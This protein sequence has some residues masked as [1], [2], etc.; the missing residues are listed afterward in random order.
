MKRSLVAGTAWLSLTQVSF[1]STKKTNNQ[2]FRNKA[3]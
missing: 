3:E 1:G 2:G